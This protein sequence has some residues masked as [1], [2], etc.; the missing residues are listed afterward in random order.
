MADTAGPATERAPIAGGPPEL[1]TGGV[2]TIDLAAI[3]G[4]L[5]RA[6][7]RA[8]RRPNAPPW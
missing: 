5:A 7:R 4:E 3:A 6:R 2:L 8:W 1:E